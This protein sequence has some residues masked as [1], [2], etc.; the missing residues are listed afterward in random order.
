MRAESESRGNRIFL[1]FEIRRRDSIK[2]STELNLKRFIKINSLS[3][4]FQICY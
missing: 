1:I 4:S 3:S 2:S